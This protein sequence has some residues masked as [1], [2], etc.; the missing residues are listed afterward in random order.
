MGSVIDYIEYPNCKSEGCYLDFYYRTGEEY[1]NCGSCGYHHSVTIK[2]RDKKLNELTEDDWEAVELKNPYGSYKIKY[3][4]S[5][6][7][8]CGSLESKKQFNELKK[9][10]EQDDTVEYFHL[11]RFVDGEIKKEIIIDNGPEYDSA[12]FHKNER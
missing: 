9:E 2:N 1:C 11:S 4:G 6:G 12:G 3:Y 10:I 7:W 8:S 5:V